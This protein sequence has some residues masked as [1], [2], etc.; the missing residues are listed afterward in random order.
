MIRPMNL[1]M[2]TNADLPT[3][4]AQGEAAVMALF[5]EGATHVAELAHQLAKPGEILQEVPARLAKTSRNSRQPPASDGE[6]QGKRT[7]S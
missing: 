5:H 2:P 3:A 6:S 1:R 7:A 4:F